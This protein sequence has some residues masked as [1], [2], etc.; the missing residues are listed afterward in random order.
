MAFSLRYNAAVVDLKVLIHFEDMSNNLTIGHLAKIG[1]MKE[2]SDPHGFQAILTLQRPQKLR[3]HQWAPS[4]MSVQ[5]SMKPISWEQGPV[6]RK[7]RKLFGPEKPFVKLPN[8]CFGKPTF[9]H[10]FKPTKRNMSVKFDDLNP[11][12]S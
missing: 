3:R 1:I 11:L 4:V 6:S 7:S 9:Q 8:A 5:C 12:H 2:R 10:V